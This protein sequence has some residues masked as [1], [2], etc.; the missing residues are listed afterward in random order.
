MCSTTNMV[1]VVLTLIVILLVVVLV[2]YL[3]KI[4]AHVL[5]W[6]S[7]DKEEEEEEGDE[8]PAAGPSQAPASDSSDCDMDCDRCPIC[9]ARLR[10]QDVG[11]PEG[12]D[13]SFCLE[14][15]QEWAKVIFLSISQIIRFCIKVD[16]NVSKYHTYHCFG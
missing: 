9:L 2:V 5:D 10:D 11:T 8:G 4:Y 3:L 15:I 7:D 12:C 13:H 16:H 14:C 1:L 6:D